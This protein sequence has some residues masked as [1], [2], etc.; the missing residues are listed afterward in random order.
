MTSFVIWDVAREGGWGAGANLRVA[1]AGMALGLLGLM[2]GIP[3]D[4]AAALLGRLKSAI[5]SPPFALGDQEVR[6]TISVGIAAGAATDERW[7]A[8][9]QRADKA[10]YEAKA[11]GRN[12]V[13]AAPLEAE[14]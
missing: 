6:C 2:L 7:D 8:L 5:E 1:C 10:L 14:S 13:V 12:Q 3:R 9:Y 4:A 11:R